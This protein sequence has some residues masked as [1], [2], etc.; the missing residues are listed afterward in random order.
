MKE[1]REFISQMSSLKVRVAEL[2]DEMVPV[3]EDHCEYR[4]FT[5]KLCLVNH[6][7]DYLE[8]FCNTEALGVPPYEHSAL[9]LKSVL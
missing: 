7:C 6:V 4:L 9:L 1:C 8:K 2:K 5:M 3:F